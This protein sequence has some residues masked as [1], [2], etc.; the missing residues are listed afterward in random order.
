MLKFVFHDTGIAVGISP[1]QSLAEYQQELR[2][3]IDDKEVAVAEVSFDESDLEEGQE[4][5]GLRIIAS[6]HHLE[7]REGGMMTTLELLLAKAFQAGVEYGRTD[8]FRWCPKN[9]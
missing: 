1:D 7:N 9:P 6:S 3:E 4:D 5:D 8:K 2:R